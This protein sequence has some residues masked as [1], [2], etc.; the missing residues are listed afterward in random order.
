MKKVVN[1]RAIM[2]KD[3]HECDA[4][5]PDPATQRVSHVTTTLKTAVDVEYSKN[6]GRPEKKRKMERWIS[7]GTSRVT[8]CRCSLSSPS[9]R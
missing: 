9:A 3:R 8:R 4:G 1:S 6:T 5:I 2:A 7:M